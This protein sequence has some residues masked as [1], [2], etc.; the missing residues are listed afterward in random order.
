MYRGELA[1]RLH[2]FSVREGGAL[3]AE[4]LE[5]HAGLWVDPIS[6]TCGDV[7]FHQIPPNGQGIA[8]L[9]ALGILRELDAFA[10]DPDGVEG[11][12][13]AIEAMKLG[14]REAHRM[15]ADPEH[16]P[17]APEEA[18]QD[19][20]I[21]A[22]AMEVDAKQAQDFNHGVPK[23]GGTVLMCAADARGR[24][25]SSV[26]YTHLTLPTICSV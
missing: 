18:L 15:V 25:T 7:T 26:S 9:F 8:M 1:E 19:E 14:F 5:N 23:P 21:H 12:H 6:M 17:E 22:L 24:A 20:R 2:D 3:R 13:L 16:L 11:A 4:D 10:L